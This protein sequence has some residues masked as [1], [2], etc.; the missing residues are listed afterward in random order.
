MNDYQVMWDEN[1][2]T[3]IY[4]TETCNS[5]FFI[6]LTVGEIDV[7]HMRASEFAVIYSRIP[8]YPV[9]RAAEL[10]LNSPVKQVV[11]SQARE[12]L[13]R[14]LADPAYAYDA[15]QFKDFVHQP[16]EKEPVMATAK[17][18]A[19]AK[20]VPA[21]KAAAKAA[22]AKKAAAK[23]EDNATYKVKDAE[24]AKRGFIKE[25]VD[26]AAKLGS[27]TR[28]KLVAKVVSGGKADEAKALRYFYYC[29]AKGIIA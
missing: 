15:S 25:F 16:L 20:K 13:A 21:K 4:L 3:C 23:R 1:R 22:P 29:T 18:A 10:Y 7:R 2:H 19:P 8:D 12:H 11:T 27:F 26:A 6:P 9:R 14:I 17:K 5:A 24:A 28:D